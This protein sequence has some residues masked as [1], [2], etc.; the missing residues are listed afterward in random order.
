[1]AERVVIG[2]AELWYGD[3]REVLPL[4]PKTVAI[5]SDPPYGIGYV[6]SGG[7]NSSEWRGAPDKDRNAAPIIGDDKPFDPGML[8]PHDRVLLFGADHYAQ[9]LPRGR[10]LVWDKL[11]GKDSWDSFSDA[12]FAWV[13]KPGAARIFRMMW[14]GLCQGAGKDKGTRR[15]HPTQK[16]VELMEWCIEQL[17]FPDVV[18][19]PYMGT[20]VCG[21]AA[22]NLGLHFIGVEI[23]RPYFDIACERVSRAQAQGCMFPPELAAVAVQQKLEL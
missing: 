7:G 9:R 19:D 2:S 12:E 14:K 16:P 20:G 5:V 8:L 1:M 10:W 21:V 4:L 3:C 6:H 18:C 11:A 22:I 13:N 23:H 15:T 17:N